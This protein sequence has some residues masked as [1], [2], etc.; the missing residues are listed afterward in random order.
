MLGRKYMGS[1]GK[2]ICWISNLVL[3]MH[4]NKTSQI[5]VLKSLA[6]RGHETSLFAV[7]SKERPQFNI[8][9]VQLIP[10]PLRYVPYFST[11]M[12]AIF[13]FIYLPF[14]FI[15]SKPDFVIVDS[16]ELTFLSVLSTILFPKSKRPKTI[17]EI[18]T[19]PVP[20]TVYIERLLFKSAIMTAKKSFDGMTII[21][22][23]M[24]NEICDKFNINPN[25]VGVWTS[26]VSITIFNPRNY[27]KLILRKRQGLYH[28]FIVFYHGS[29]GSYVTGHARGVVAIIKAIELL[30]NECPDLILFLLS[31]IRNCQWIRELVVDCNIQGNVILHDK[32][33][34]ENVPKYIAICDCGLIPA[35]NIPEWRN[36]SPLKLLEYL[37]MEKVVI[38]TDI[39]AIRY[40][41]GESKCAIYIPSSSPEEIA[42]AILYVYDNKEKLKE[43]GALG[44]KIVE[45]NY[46]WEKVAENFE[47]YLLSLDIQKQA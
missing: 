10:I 7:Y 12:Y 19:T 27:D 5:E 30:K 4:L 11:L 31:D 44:R 25:K 15:Y 32:V 3:D 9:D 28:K 29:L 14:H 34:Y 2:R 22:P 41:M 16:H 37:A 38:A 39:L 43:W 24:R 35:L 42:K 46:S 21:T 40:I 23:M 26:G 6:K 1:H 36:Q 45:E 8:E 47:H 17:L 13:L 33:N 18:R 20:G